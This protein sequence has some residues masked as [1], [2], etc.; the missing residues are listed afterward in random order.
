MGSRR[1]RKASRSARRLLGLDY[2]DLLLIHW[3]NPSKGRFVDAWRGMIKLLEAGKVR[4]IGVSNFK[5][6]HIHK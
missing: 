6:A 4:A 2:V 3:P 1:C 5:P